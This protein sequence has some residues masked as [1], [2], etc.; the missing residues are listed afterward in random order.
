MNN[1]SGDHGSGKNLPP[2]SGPKLHALPLLDS[3]VKGWMRTGEINQILKLTFSKPR[4]SLRS[5]QLKL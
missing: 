1:L 2:G 4:S 3:E 5:M